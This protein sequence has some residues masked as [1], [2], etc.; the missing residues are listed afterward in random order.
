MRVTLCD[1]G[2]ARRPP[3]RAGRLGAGGAGG[4]GQPARGERAS[5]GSRRRRSCVTTACRRWP[6]PR[7]SW[8]AIEPR[9]GTEYAGLVL[10][11][12]GFERLRATSL[13]RVNC[14]L[15]ATEAFNERNGNMSLDEA[16]AQVDGDPCR[17]RPANDGNGQ[18]RLR[19]SLRGTCR[20]R[21]GRR[22][23]RTARRGRGRARGHDRR[24]HAHEGQAPGR[25]CPRRAHVM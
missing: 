22:S 13:G 12:K 4:A 25:A 17:V 9:P 6:A 19:M 18:R 7:R 23:L 8:P 14:T 16:L 15:A 1:V 2:P 11:L 20:S 24:R 21:M 3:E 5:R 10:N